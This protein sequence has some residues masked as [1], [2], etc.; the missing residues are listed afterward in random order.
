MPSTSKLLLLPSSC[1]CLP[2]SAKDCLSLAPLL[3]AQNHLAPLC[4]S[5]SSCPHL[6]CSAQDCLFLAPLLTAQNRIAPLSALLCL[7]S[8]H[9][10]N[11]SLA[12]AFTSPSSSPLPHLAGPRSWPS[13]TIPLQNDSLKLKIASGCFIHTLVSFL[14]VMCHTVCI[15]DCRV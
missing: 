8:F 15:L 13:C 4:L 1:P 3:A 7:T 10:G 14:S 12:F 6:L 5:L 9:Y 2:R 11:S